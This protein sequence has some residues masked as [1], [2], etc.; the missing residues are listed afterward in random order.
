MRITIDCPECGAAKRPVVA[1]ADC[2]AERGLA[3]LPAWREGL[4]AR[5]TAILLAEPDRDPLPP[6]PL[7][8]PLRVVIDADELLSES[9]TL[10]VPD[11]V[12]LP[13]N[14]LSFDWNERRGLRR[15]RK[16]A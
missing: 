8:R 4:R 16:S 14:P 13:A 1:C 15:L 11:T 7:P 12:A 2:G 5:S 6:V 10:I 9:E 3:D